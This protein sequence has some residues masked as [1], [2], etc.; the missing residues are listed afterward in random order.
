MLLRGATIALTPRPGLE[1]SQSDLSWDDSC[2]LGLRTSNLYYSEIESA[3]E[4]AGADTATNQS[5][6]AVQVQQTW[7]PVGPV[8]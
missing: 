2:Q 3:F 8:E 7:Q 1:A 4:C 6:L 5:R